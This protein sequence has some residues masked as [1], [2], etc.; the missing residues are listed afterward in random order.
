M[1]K[2]GFNTLSKTS[3]LAQTEDP[4]L[5][6]GTTNVFHATHMPSA[7][8]LLAKPTQILTSDLQPL[9]FEVSSFRWRPEKRAARIRADLA[10]LYHYRYPVNPKQAI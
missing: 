8:I 6:K 5:M 1:K 3:D 7:L 10:C 2:L 4:V 9:L